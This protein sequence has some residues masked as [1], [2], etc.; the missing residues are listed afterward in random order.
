M[1]SVSEES[2]TLQWE[3]LRAGS[4]Y[5][6]KRSGRYLI[7]E[8]SGEHLTLSTSARNGGQT[9]TVRYLA[10]HQSC[11]ATMHAERH[12]IIK[13]YG[14]GKYHD[15][16]CRE[17]GLPWNEVALM[18]TAANMNYAAIRTEE[19]RGLEVTAVVTAG[20]QGN[21]V[22]AGDPA[23]W[24]EGESGWEKIGGT[25]NTMLLVNHPVTESALARSVVTMTEAKTA[26]L[27]RLAVRSLYS[28][29]LATGT[30]T[31]QFAITAP[32]AGEYGLTSASPHVKF[33]ELIG[34]AV[35]DATLEALRW[36]NGL[37]PS[38]TRSIF[39]ALGRF[40][41]REG[42]FFEDIANMLSEQDLELLRKND[43]S[44]FYDPLVSASAYAIAAVLD[45]IHYETLPRSASR[46]ALRQQAASLA[47]SLAAKSYLWDRFRA[48]LNDEDPMRL[49]VRAVALGWSAK[50]Q[51]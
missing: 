32:E 19:D 48:Q 24:R 40:G 9:R 15:I 5:S 6:L 29:D 16:V 50:W 21:A 1:S 31:D 22:C 17:T 30:G 26:A 20:V 27:Q 14:E 10:N 8:L 38:Y 35:R 43:K 11:E 47:A 13:G 25:I 51:S 46:E 4:H 3:L 7:A 28:R 12:A 44:V 37:E 36:Q 2:M 18:G 41:L 34:R 39:T 23:G 42:T 33:G 49:V 45:R